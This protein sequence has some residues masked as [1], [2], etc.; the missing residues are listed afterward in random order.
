MLVPR[1]YTYCY[2]EADLRWQQPQRIRTRTVTWKCFHRV[3][4]SWHYAESEYKHACIK[5]VRIY[6]S[7]TC[8][9]S[10]VVLKAGPQ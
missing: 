6:A 10:A 4:E 3:T 9:L 5:L 7:C 1:G 2:T 8:L